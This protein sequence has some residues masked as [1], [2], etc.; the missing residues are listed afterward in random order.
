M[1]RKSKPRVCWLQQDLNNRLAVAPAVATS[2]A[3]P[4]P[5]IVAFTGPGLTSVNDTQIIPLVKDE[6]QSEAVA[7]SSLSDLQNSGY[8]LRR[9]VGKLNFLVSQGTAVAAGD[10]SLFMV[11]AGMIILRCSNGILPNIAPASIDPA[12]L[13]TTE[14]PWMWRRSWILSDN[15]G[16][17]V[18]GNNIVGPTDNLQYGGGNMD[19]PH[20][21]AKVARLVNQDERL[22]LVVSVAGLNGNAQAANPGLILLV[23]ELRYLASMRT[24]IGNR[25]NASR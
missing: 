11:T 24:T 22:F 20:V 4:S 8:R 21:D 12:V 9:V 2:P 7:T 13:Q 25:R 23:G 6:G 16:A 14:D 1:R 10:P 18:V 3:D 5:F 15:T 19:G 17:G